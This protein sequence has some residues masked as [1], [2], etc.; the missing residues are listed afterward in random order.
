MGVEGASKFT[1]LM[2]ER[3]HR[4]RHVSV[5]TDFFI[6]FQAWDFTLDQSKCKLWFELRAGRITA[7]NMYR[8]T[9]SNPLKPSVTL[10]RDICYPYERRFECQAVRYGKRHEGDGAD[11]Y[12]S[13]MVQFHQVFKMMPGG[14]KINRQYPFYGASPDR[15]VECLCC[16]AG[17]LEIKCPLTVADKSIDQWHLDFLEIGPT[18]MSLKREHPYYYQC[19]TQM[20]LC[21]VGYCDFVVWGSKAMYLER[22][23]VDPGLWSEIHAKASVFHEIVIWPEILMKHFTRS[24]VKKIKSSI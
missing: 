14:F 4:Q 7:S 10:I 16:G 11:R 8:A 19:I 5:C 15:L 17:V 22:I 13:H 1:Y 9:H 20:I 6:H 24:K 3:S 2:C 21:D 18:G 12:H 23:Y